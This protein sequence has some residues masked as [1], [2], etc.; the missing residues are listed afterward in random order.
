MIKEGNMIFWEAVTYNKAVLPAQSY[1]DFKWI[2]VE[3]EIHQKAL[4]LIA[5]LQGEA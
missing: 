3:E 5:V 2:S 4:N 1:S